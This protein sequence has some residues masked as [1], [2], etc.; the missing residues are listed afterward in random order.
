MTRLDLVKEVVALVRRNVSDATLADVAGAVFLR[1]ERTLSRWLN[2]EGTVP[3]TVAG[4]LRAWRAGHP[5]GAWQEPN[6][7]AVVTTD[8]FVRGRRAAKG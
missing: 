4:T 1:D 5:R 8:A 3:A 7:P 6:H 2:E